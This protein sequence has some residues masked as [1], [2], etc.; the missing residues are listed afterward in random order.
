MRGGLAAAALI[1]TFALSSAA[2]AGDMGATMSGKQLLV[3]GSAQRVRDADWIRRHLPPGARVT[4]ADVTE[5][6]ATL[7]LM[8]PG[9]REALAKLTDARL[10][11]DAFPYP[12]LRE[13]RVADAP[14]RAVR[15]SYV[16]ELGW[17]LYVPRER[18]PGVYDA[19][20]AA[21]AT[22]AGYYALDSLRLEKG[23]RAWGHELS[24]RETALEAGMAFTVAWNKPGGFIGRDALLAQRAR[25]IA[26][27]LLLF[28]LDE[29]PL[30]AWG[31]EPIYRDGRCV[32]VLTSAG[33]GHT[34]GRLVGMGYAPLAP[35]ETHADLLAARWEVDIAG[36][37]V[38]ATASLR[39][40]W[41]PTG[42]RM[43][44]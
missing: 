29:T 8:G 10:D 40:W 32:G 28:R 31:E 43:K 19:L 33:F 39:P 14:V 30:M 3:T 11:T 17:E 41:D 5:D 13:I 22:D 23:Y 36:T 1:V 35:G 9:S 34:V 44:A 26:Q 24:P 21:G 27:R 38:G 18:A 20:V 4:L 7:S 25:G 37:R 42:A 6:W 16:G 12:S 2:F 15:I